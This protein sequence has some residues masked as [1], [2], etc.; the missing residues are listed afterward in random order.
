MLIVFVTSDNVVDPTTHANLGF[1][2]SNQS[3]SHGGEVV[4]PCLFFRL[5]TFYILAHLTDYC[6]LFKFLHPTRHKVGNFGDA[7]LYSQPLD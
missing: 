3:V 7:L 5:S 2:G 4:T 1:H 6:L